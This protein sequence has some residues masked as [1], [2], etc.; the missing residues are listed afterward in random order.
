MSGAVHPLP[1]CAVV[2]CVGTT[3]PLPVQKKK[4][5]G[6]HLDALHMPYWSAFLQK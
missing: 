3:L 4:H 1:V 2:G 5:T 6:R